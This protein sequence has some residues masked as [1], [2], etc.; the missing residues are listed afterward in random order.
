MQLRIELVGAEPPIWRRVLVPGSVRLS[1]LRAM[2]QAAIGWTD[3]HLH[4]FR[5]GDRLYGTR[6]PDPLPDEIDEKTATVDQALRGVDR[7]VYE[8]DFGDGWEHEVTIESRPRRPNGLKC[9]VCVD[10][11]NACPPEDSGGV[12]GY[13]LMLDALA[14]PSHEDHAMYLEWLDGPFDAEAFDLTAINVALQR[15]R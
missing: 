14:D 3:S 4:C 10:G 5:I 7:F 8:H 6:F 9:A 11:Q 2:L 12:H 15:V 13:A 1:K